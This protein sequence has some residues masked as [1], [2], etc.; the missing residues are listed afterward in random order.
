[1]LRNSDYVDGAW[2]D[3]EIAPAVIVSYAPD[4]LDHHAS[5]VADHL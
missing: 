1:M 2:S 3:T 4:L 5:A